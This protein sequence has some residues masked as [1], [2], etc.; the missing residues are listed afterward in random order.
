MQVP[1]STQVSMKD[2]QC[3]FLFSLILDVHSWKCCREKLKRFDFLQ[4]FL[5]LLDMVAVNVAGM[6]HTAVLPRA[7]N[8]TEHQKLQCEGEKKNCIVY[9]QFKNV[10]FGSI[11]TNAK[12]VFFLQNAL[13]I[14]SFISSYSLLVGKSSAVS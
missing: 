14:Y 3:Y 10:Q 12:N 9:P 6:I 7:G 8:A 11:S 4:Q 2:R 1:L 5:T 13:K